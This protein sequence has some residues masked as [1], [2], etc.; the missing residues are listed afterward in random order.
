MKISANFLL[1]TI[2]EVGIVELTK[3]VMTKRKGGN[4]RFM[5]I[6]F[7]FLMSYPVGEL[8]AAPKQCPKIDQAM[9]KADK[10]KLVMGGE[11]DMEGFRWRVIGGN[12]C[13]PTCGSEYQQAQETGVKIESKFEIKKPEGSAICYYSFTQANVTVA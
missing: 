12:L 10:E 6:S 11:L 5:L 8:A 2:R 9:L 13:N 3:H 7:A 4:M 1:Y